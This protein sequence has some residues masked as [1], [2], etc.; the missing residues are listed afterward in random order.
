MADD[1]DE[2]IGLHQERGERG[3]PQ[4]IPSGDYSCDWTHVSYEIVWVVVEGG[5]Y[6]FHVIH[7][8]D[9]D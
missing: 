5:L 2:F 7:G 1:V 8:N 9:E 4:P 3:T 6:L